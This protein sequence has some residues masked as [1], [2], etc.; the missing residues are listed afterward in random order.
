MNSRPFTVAMVA[1]MPYPMTKASCIRV[2]HL[3]HNLATEYDDIRVKL[4]AYRGAGEPPEQHPRIEYH[5]V[6]GFEA[7]GAKYYAWSN[8][9][10]VDA[11][12]IRQMVGQRR[13]IDVI[14]CHTIEGLGIALAFKALTFSRAPIC[15][16][17][18]GPVVP[19][20][21]HYRMIPNWRPVVAAVETLERLML[22]FVC[23]AF[24][25]NEGLHRLLN[26]RVLRDRVS[27]VFDYVDPAVFDP[28][29][30]DRER[31][32]ALRA[33]Y[34]SGG[35]QLLTYVGMFKDYQGVDYLIRAFAEL[36]L[37]HSA[38]RL[39]LIGDGPCRGDYERLIGQLGLGDRVL[40]PGLVPHRDVLNWLDIADIVISPRI[41]NEITQAGFVSQLP[42]YMAV[43]K[44]IVATSVSGCPYL[45]RDGAGI[46]VEPNDERALVRGIETALAL[47]ADAT[48]VMVRKARENAAQFTWKQGIG[49]V[50]RVYRQLLAAGAS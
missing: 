27:V 13:S 50:Y 40:L 41:D 34:K 26:E 12:L 7:G 36:A 15:M 5:L 37:R 29:R 10:R 20:L 17:V 3:V 11:R 43:G 33:Q 2:G 46:L 49:A 39:M 8:K 9:L 48:E 38:L 25:S 23:H 14:H 28:A 24:V 45:L 30:I 31:V 42:E 44:V 32:A 6:A 21:V 47:P 4:F 16:D 22:S 35:E 18:H 1:G 19:E